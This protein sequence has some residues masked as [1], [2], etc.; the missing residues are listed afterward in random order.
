MRI[1]GHTHYPT[2]GGEDYDLL[3]LSNGRVL[4]IGDDSVAI[5]ASE[6]SFYRGFGTPEAAALTPYALEAGLFRPAQGPYM[7][8]S[9]VVSEVVQCRG[10]EVIK[11]ITRRGIRIEISDDGVKLLGSCGTLFARLGYDTDCVPE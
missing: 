7:A 4:C 11:V 10:E 6:E 8:I 1:T 2:G 3:T 5:Y 9:E